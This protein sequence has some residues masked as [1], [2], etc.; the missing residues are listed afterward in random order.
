MGVT[1]EL[2]CLMVAAPMLRHNIYWQVEPELFSHDAEGSGGT[3]VVSATIEQK[4]ANELWRI[5]DVRGSYTTNFSDAHGLDLGASVLRRRG[6]QTPPEVVA[7]ARYREVEVPDERYP[8]RVLGVGVGDH[9]V[10]QMEAKGWEVD[11]ITV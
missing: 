8:K 11:R 9:F 10:E 3:A 6:Q 1:D 4:L 7:A 2:L 5:S